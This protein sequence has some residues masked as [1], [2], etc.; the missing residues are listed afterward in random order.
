MFFKRD[1]FCCCIV[2]F[3]LSFALFCPVFFCQLSLA[4]NDP[5]RFNIHSMVVFGDGSSDNGN[6]YR[7]YHFPVMPPYWYG[8]FSN[9]P[10][11]VEYL[12]HDLNIIPN[13]LEHPGYDKQEFLRDY[14]YFNAVV[15]PQNRDMGMKNPPYTPPTFAQE[16]SSY[17]HDRRHN[18]YVANTLAV[19]DIGSN[20]AGAPQCLSHPL[21]CLQ[22][23]TN[24][25][26]K[27]IDRLCTAGI[28]HFLL[29]LPDDVRTK[30]GFRDMV[31]NNQFQNTYSILVDNYISEFSSLKL[32]VEGSFPKVKVALF[33][34]IKTENSL[35]KQFPI[36]ESI[37]CYNNQRLVYDR[38]VPGSV[39]C[40]NPNQHVYYDNYFTSTHFKS[41]FADACYLKLQQVG[42]VPSVRKHWWQRLVHPQ[43]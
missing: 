32:R 39:I 23:I 22:G 9:G 15:L 1:Y 6:T 4:K 28:T 18:P 40:S 3:L 31:S 33:S 43:R 24:E 29:I 14:A 16:V 10:V 11:F 27:Q 20:D 7:V 42:W 5:N 12:A 2:K 17:L 36:P 41:L 19:I 25:S 26:E 13:P 35:V 38:V 37:P 8:R 21:Q 34:A 30:P